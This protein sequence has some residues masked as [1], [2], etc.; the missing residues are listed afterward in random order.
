MNSIQDLDFSKLG[1]AGGRSGYPGL[2]KITTASFDAGSVI[3]AEGSKFGGV[4]FVLRG[5]AKTEMTL[6][7]DAMLTSLALSGDILGIDSFHC[8]TYTSSAICV[9]DL[10]AVWL[11]AECFRLLLSTSGNFRLRIE[12]AI[13]KAIVECTTMIKLLSKNEAEAKV[14]YLLLKIFLNTSSDAR[15]R[16]SFNLGL[17]R[18]EMAEFLGL[19]VETVSRKL[20]ALRDRGV[21]RVRGRRIHV[22]KVDELQR[23]GSAVS[24]AGRLGLP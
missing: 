9:S 15:K 5:I 22:R 1:L 6:D 14:A 12:E 8:P 4:Y 24:K 23:I 20:A 17:S 11:S 21:I 16:N 18:A 10:S 19:R 13:G 7:G 2:F 3:Y